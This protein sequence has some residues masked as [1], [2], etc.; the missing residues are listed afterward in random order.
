MVVV[1]AALV[2]DVDSGEAGAEVAEDDEEGTVIRTSDCAPTAATIRKAV[3]P[4]VPAKNRI[5]R[6]NPLI[7]RPQPQKK[8]LG[9][10]WYV[11]T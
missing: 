2:V 1:V 4:A 3:T 10:H 9:N 8:R 5:R 6:P 11:T 7:T